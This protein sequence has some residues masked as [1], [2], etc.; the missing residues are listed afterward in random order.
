M[1]VLRKEASGF[2]RKDEVLPMFLKDVERAI[3]TYHYLLPRGWRLIIEGKATNEVLK[4]DLQSD[5]GGGSFAEVK[6]WTLQDETPSKDRAGKY[7]TGG[8]CSGHLLQVIRNRKLLAEKCVMYQQIAVLYHLSDMTRLQ[9]EWLRDEVGYTN[10]YGG[11]RV[12]YE[13]D[14]SIVERAQAPTDYSGEICIAFSGASEE[15]DAMFALRILREVQ[16]HLCWGINPPYYDLS[17]LYKAPLLRF[18]LEEL[19]MKETPSSK[20]FH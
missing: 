15:Q 3:E 20:D 5:K 9:H 11:I 16:F 1:K 8:D 13:R 10:F 4:L 7:Y 12:P 14:F 18:W 2:W 6:M 17:E 19:Q